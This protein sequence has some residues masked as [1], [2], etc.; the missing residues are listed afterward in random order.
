MVKAGVA[1]LGDDRVDCKGAVMTQSPVAEPQR[2]APD[3]Y[4]IPNLVA[5]RA[6]HVR[7]REL[8]GDPRRAARRRRHGRPAAPRAVARRRVVDRRPRRRALGVPLP[9]RRRPHRQHGRLPRRGPERQGRRQLLQQRAGRPRARSGDADRAPGLAGG[10]H[11]VRRRRPPP[12]P[13]PPADLRRPDDAWPVRRAHRRD[14]GG[15][16]VRRADHRRRVRRRRPAARPVRRHVRPVQQHDLALAP[17]AGPQALP[18]PRRRRRGAR[19][20]RSSPR[21]TARS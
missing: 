12:A 3:T 6:G 1:R 5:G 9:R 15:R 20:R 16:L 10:R 4:L 18:P 11:V 13:V 14:V 2:I 19:R 21:R 8:A 7:V 17:V